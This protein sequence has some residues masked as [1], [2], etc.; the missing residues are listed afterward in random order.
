MNLMR[1]YREMLKK[2]KLDGHLVAR[3][4]TEFL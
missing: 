3:R 4:N 2:E 1:I